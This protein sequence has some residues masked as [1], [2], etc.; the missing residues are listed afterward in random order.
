MASNVTFVERLRALLQQRG[1]VKG[2]AVSIILRKA[3]DQSV[4]DLT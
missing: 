3:E 4:A 2:S 1:R